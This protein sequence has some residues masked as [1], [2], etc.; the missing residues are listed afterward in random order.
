MPGAFQVEG[1][2]AVDRRGLARRDEG[3][4]HYLV[5]DRMHILAFGL[6]SMVA[7]LGLMGIDGRVPARTT[8][9]VTSVERS[10]MSRPPLRIADPCGLGAYG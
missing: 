7:A 8:D 1:W 4:G 10:G 3:H 6:V 9:C 2:P 5:T